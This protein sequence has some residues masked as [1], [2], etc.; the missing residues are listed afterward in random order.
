MSKFLDEELTEH[1]LMLVASIHILLQSK[2]SI[3]NLKRAEQLLHEFV[4]D[5]ER[6]Y[7]KV[8]MTFNVHLLLH[9]ARSVLNWG[10][11]YE[12]SAFA[13]EAGNATLLSNI[14]AA[15]GVHK[16]ICRHITLKSSYREL[17]KRIEPFAKDEIKDF[18]SNMN[19]LSV[20]KTEKHSTTRYFGKSVRVS[21]FLKEKLHLSDMARSYNK[22]TKDGCLYLS[23]LKVN[24]RS[25]NS[26]ARFKCGSFIKIVSFVIDRENNIEC[27]ICNN[28]VT[29][30]AFENAN[31]LLQKIAS[32]DKNVKIVN[33][34]EIETIC[35]CLKVNNDEYI[36]PVP[37]LYFY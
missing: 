16:Q 3:V 7:S 34:N 32:V 33:T 26:C 11:L 5:A 22:I 31:A 1:W 19:K 15:K 28:L 2:I 18:C 36:C 9:L 35:V 20:Q 10:P 27:T 23:S 24:K 37:N 21:P 25:D 8:A 12:H 14:H 6:L 17:Q 4:Y 30:N 29:Y 13:F